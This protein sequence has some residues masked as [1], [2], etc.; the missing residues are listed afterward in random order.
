MIGD[1]HASFGIK[2]RVFGIVAA[3]KTARTRLQMRLSKPHRPK[4]GEQ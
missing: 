4:I 2:V 1:A 3:M